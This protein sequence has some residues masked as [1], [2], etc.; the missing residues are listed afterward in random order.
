ML[1]VEQNRTEEA[2]ETLSTGIINKG[3]RQ[4][5]SCVLLFCIGSVLVTSRT[6]SEYSSVKKKY[7]IH[8]E[9]TF[10]CSPLV[11]RN[12]VWLLPRGLHSK[13]YF[14]FFFFFFFFWG[15]GGGISIDRRT[16]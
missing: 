5:Q 16:K 6:R 11:K 7:K 2:P 4:V 1:K 8:H 14:F 10:F 3:A 13:Q 15:G 9:P 12:P